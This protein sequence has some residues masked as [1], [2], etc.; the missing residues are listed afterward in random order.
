MLSKYPALL[1]LYLHLSVQ[2]FIVTVKMLLANLPII[3][4]QE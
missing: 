3:I 2:A 4:Q 1:S